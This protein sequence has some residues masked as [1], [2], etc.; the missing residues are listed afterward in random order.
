MQ[1]EDGNAVSGH[2]LEETRETGVLL[3][4]PDGLAL[5]SH[6]SAVAPQAPSCLSRLVTRTYEIV[7]SKP[8]PHSWILRTLHVSNTKWRSLK[9]VRCHACLQL[10]TKGP[11]RVP[12]TCEGP[13]TSYGCVSAILSSAITK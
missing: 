5:A 6:S 12:G 8:G 1:V 3:A 10:L 11:T 7:T 9:N 13:V 2:L 4:Y